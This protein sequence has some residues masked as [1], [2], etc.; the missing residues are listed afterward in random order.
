MYVKTVTD[1]DNMTD[2]YNDSLSI[3]NIC[4]NNENNFDVIIPTSLLTLP[5]GLL[6][7]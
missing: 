1:Y 2:D 6:F 7:L 5:G 4:T 3:N